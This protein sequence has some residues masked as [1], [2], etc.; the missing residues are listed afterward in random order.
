M[1][2]RGVRSLKSLQIGAARRAFLLIV[3]ALLG[4]SFEARAE[5]RPAA[6]SVDGNCSVAADTQRWTKQEIFVWERV[7]AGAIA[8]FN[9]G[10]AY[11]G[12]L[13]PNGPEGLPESRILRRKFLETILLEDKY[14]SVLTRHGVRIIGAR[15]KERV[16][17]VN[18]D[19][20]HELW[21]N[22]SLLE[23]G[24]D[25][26]G[27]KSSNLLSFDGSKVTGAFTANWSRIDQ[28]LNMRKARF[29]D[30]VMGSTHIGGMLELDGSTVSGKL[31]LGKLHVDSSLSMG[32]GHFS[33]V[34]LGS[35]HIGGTLGLNGS[36]VS[37]KLNLGTLH[38]DSS[39]FMG[40][41]QFSEVVLGSAHIGGTLELNGSTVSGRLNMDKLHVDSSL[42]MRNGQFSE[43][44]LASAHIGGTLQLNGSTVSG[45]LN[46]DKLRV[47]SS[48][49]M[50]SAEFR[51]VVLGSA[52]IN[53]TLELTG[54][55]VRGR[56]YMDKLRVDS[57]LDMSN[58]AHF[59]E[60]NLTSAHIGGQLTMKN[61]A[62]TGNLRCYNLTVDQDTF[63]SDAHFPG[64]IDCTFSKFKNLDLTK[65]TF[66]DDVNLGSAQISG[67]LLLGPAGQHSAR[68]SPGK[69]L[70]LRNARAE[71]IPML[72]DAWPADFDVRGFSYRVLPE[73][74]A[75][76]HH[77]TT[78]CRPDLFQCWFGKQKSFSPQPYEQLAL[79]F[80]NQGGDDDA[81]TIRYLGRERERSESTGLKYA[82]LTTLDWAIGYGHRIE[83]ALGWT[84]GLM[85]LG[86]IVLRISGEGPKHGLPVGLSYSFDMLLPIIKLRDAHYEIDLK[87][88]PRYYFYVHKVAGF[89][90]ASFL[91]A[92]ISGLTK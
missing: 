25:F 55:K 36:T 29:A 71:T 41:G 87:G 38:V 9:D 69:T 80:Q 54:S 77:P 2:G 12:K 30:I 42:F 31:S 89:V 19:L 79:V 57:A 26:S 15:F 32:N 13:D 7:C 56:L 64:G 74:P 59:A 1:G 76:S 60:V 17:L 72:A 10:T 92:G 82:W 3:L 58:N 65:S 33:E 67:E 44:V 46:M 8:D 5:G 11:G 48:L 21:L 20:G 68:W 40:N 37:G 52:H 22:N 53:G 23:Q 39:L 61:A 6:P 49:L 91:V 28:A 90:L 88:W 85:F 66:G 45:R 14:R 62:V 63:L 86:A 18:A 43:I 83:R 81:R 73:D 35:A 16:D 78:E 50:H 70:I 4:A 34:V 51:E 47:D 84:I 27:A 75:G 24:A